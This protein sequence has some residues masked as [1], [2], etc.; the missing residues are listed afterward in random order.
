MRG[1]VSVALALGLATVACN[2]GSSSS[3]TTPSPTTTTD[4]LMG[5]VQP[6]VNG[7]L[8]SSSNNFVVGQGGGNITISLTSAIE[9]LPG[10]TLLTTVQMGM[11][12]GTPSGS[13][14]TLLANAFTTGAAGSASLN[15][16]IAAGNYCVQ[17]S[18]ITG[19]LGPVAYA[20]AVTHP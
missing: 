9:T 19:Q 17:V 4:V 5:T 11:G 18:D 10:G 14:C 3:T 13:S 20:V 1:Y 2:N 15:G 12:V 16:S 7:V 6:P 8:Q